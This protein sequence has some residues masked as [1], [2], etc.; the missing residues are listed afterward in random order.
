[1]NVQVLTGLWIF[2]EANRKPWVDFFSYQPWVVSL[3]RLFDWQ[4]ICFLSNDKCNENVNSLHFVRSVFDAKKRAISKF[5]PLNNTQTSFESRTSYLTFYFIEKSNMNLT[6]NHYYCL[7]VW[8]S[9]L[10]LCRKNTASFDHVLV[11]SLFFVFFFFFNVLVSPF[12]S[13]SYSL[14]CKQL[15]GRNHNQIVRTEANNNNNRQER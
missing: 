8:V 7:L 14:A 1:M 6:H 10:F 13:L 2:A 9:S 3:L 4:I 15:N 5:K 11:Y 12:N